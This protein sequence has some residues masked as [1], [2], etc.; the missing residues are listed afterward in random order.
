MRKLKMISVITLTVVSC[1]MASEASAQ[2]TPTL[3][4]SQPFLTPSVK[5]ERLVS[6]KTK[7]TV[8]P[9]PVRASSKLT[10]HKNVYGRTIKANM[11]EKTVSTRFIYSRRKNDTLM[12]VYFGDEAKKSR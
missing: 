7:R 12:P 8:R 6:P 3:D 5:T 4:I 11:S 2:S 10:R 1:A 9:L